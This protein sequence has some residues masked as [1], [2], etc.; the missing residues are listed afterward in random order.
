[1]SPDFTDLLG[2]G[3]LNLVDQRLTAGFDLR[4]A[5]S[6]IFLIIDACKNSFACSPGFVEDMSAILP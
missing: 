2:V 6:E 3:S 1:L 5:L 4:Q